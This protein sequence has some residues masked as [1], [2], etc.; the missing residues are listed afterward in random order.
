MQISLQVFVRR[1]ESR[2]HTCGNQNDHEDLRNTIDPPSALES[3]LQFPESKQREQRREADR[4]SER[5]GFRQGVPKQKKKLLE[6]CL[7]IYN[8][9]QF[10]QPKH[11]DELFAVM[12]MNYMKTLV[13]HHGTHIM[14]TRATAV[15]KPRRSARLN[16][17]SMNPNLKTPSKK[18]IRPTCLGCSVEITFQN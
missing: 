5:I 14:I 7:R 16:T 3:I 18:D 13:S 11:G 17:T 12:N 2:K 10:G 8:T 9:H 4:S 1:K 15:M 6:S